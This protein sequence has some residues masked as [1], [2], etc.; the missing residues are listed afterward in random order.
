MLRP[1]ESDCAVVLRDTPQGLPAAR[2]DELRARFGANDILDAPVARWSDILRD[3]LRDP[4]L[5]FLVV[6]SSLFVFTGDYREAI[7]LALAIIPLAGMDIWL[8]RRTRV[9]TATLG[10]RLATRATVQR[11]GVVQEI[12]SAD[13]VV[14]DLVLLASGQAFPADGLIVGGETIQVDESALTGEAYPVRKTPLDIVHAGG[15]IDSAHWGFAGTRVLSGSLQ[16]RVCYTGGRTYY[17]EIVRSAIQ[18]KHA[19]TPLQLAITDLVKVLL[20]VAVILCVIVAWVRWSQGFGLIDAL[21]SAMTLAVAALPEEFPVVFTFF[22]GVGVYRLAQRHALVRRAVAVEN[23]GRVTVIAVDKTGTVT[24]GRLVL[25]HL[26]P[27]K[28][29]S[30]QDLL[31]VSICAAR[32]DSDDPLDVAI[33]SH[34]SATAIKPHR[35]F[36]FPF[37]ED[38]KRETAIVRGD[39]GTLLVATKGAHETILRMCLLDREQQQY[40]QHYA[41]ELA[42]EGHKVIACARQQSV[43]SDWSEH[44]PDSGFEFVGL[45]ALED[46][47]REGV[48]QSI[49][50]CRRAGIHVLMI[51][52]D[53]PLTARAVA[54]EIGLGAPEPRVVLADEI[55]Q[56]IASG[57]P[58]DLRHVD[59]I[60]RSM[61][62]Q[63]L[64]F[65]RQLQAMGESVA[66]TGDGVNDV[67]ALQAADVGIAMGEH[68]TQAAREVSAVVL[69]DDNFRTIVD[70]V[71]EGYQ[72]FRNLRLSFA[73]LLMIHVPLVI[74]ATVIP[75][76]GFPLLYLPIHIV[77]LELIIHP[78]ALLVFQHTGQK[79]MPRRSTLAGARFF[80]RMEWAMIVLIG[81]VFTAIVGGGYLVSVE[82]GNPEHGRAMALAIMT[83]GGAGVTAVL[84]RLDS[85]IARAIVGLTVLMS[86]LLIQY[87]ITATALHLQPLHINDWLLALLGS[88]VIVAI[89][90]LARIRY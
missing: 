42:A 74:S 80:S 34:P 43:E 89:T 63:K 29:Y 64:H 77:W 18:G 6:T 36:S 86:V 3:T 40:W 73:Y 71:I 20:I 90:S 66:V 21:I 7:V 84:S 2:V 12:A 30:E 9:S 10:G 11:D 60:A 69:M 39:D 1:I 24:E 65:S 81:F 4:M 22:L 62:S 35:L 53:H 45:L 68:G 59:V 87:P 76:A 44:E 13:L 75:L 17:G 51:T 55:E 52:G 58:M 82:G 19:R 8:H 28:N 23:I 79:V 32:E 5:W 14:G 85:S 72:L 83:L 46:P 50:V 15:S 49:E 56:S 70:A 16:M 54:R 61:P 67:P 26:Y 27:A 47:V 33:L 78:T 37:T 31:Y 38:R 41:E 48:T 57:K 88:G 25:S